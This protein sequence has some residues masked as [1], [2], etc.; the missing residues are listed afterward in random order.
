MA[1]AQPAGACCGGR[2]SGRRP[3]ADGW[4]DARPLAPKRRAPPRDAASPQAAAEPPGLSAL[5]AGPAPAPP[6]SG[7]P[8]GTPSDLSPQAPGLQ[9]QRAD[10]CRR[11]LGRQRHRLRNRGIHP[12]LQR[13]QHGDMRGW[14]DIGRAAEVGGSSS[15]SPCNRRQSRH[16]GFCATTL[17]AGASP[18]RSRR[19]YCHAW[20]GSMP[21]EQ[22]SKKAMLTLPVGANETRWLF[23][24]PCRW[25]AACTAGGRWPSGPGSRYGLGA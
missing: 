22:L 19:R 21:V 2:L 1:C 18:M 13:R 23:L 20:A 6:A 3:A 16:A 8:A 17:R 7:D 15:P 10:L 4:P 9:E 12:G 5:R 11:A 25:M 24:R 14:G